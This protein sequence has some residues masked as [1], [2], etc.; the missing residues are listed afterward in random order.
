MSHISVKTIYTKQLTS[1]VSALVDMSITMS[2]TPVPQ[3][4]GSDKTV[5][6]QRHGKA[7]FW[8]KYQCL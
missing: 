7:S 4:H 2:R 1:F 8:S 3:A 6:A 5:E